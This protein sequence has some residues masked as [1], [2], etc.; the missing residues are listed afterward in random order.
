MARCTSGPT[1]GV[2][3]YQAGKISVEQLKELED[4]GCPGCGSCSGMFTAN[5]IN[6]LCEAL[7]IALPGNGTVLATVAR[8]IPLCVSL[9]V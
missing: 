4:Y 5:S 2:G 8:Q 1:G 3:A 6:C 7:G 9:D